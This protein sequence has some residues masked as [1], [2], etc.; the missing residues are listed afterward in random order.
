ASTTPTTT[1]TLTSTS[2]V[3][4]VAAPQA[5][6]YATFDANNVMSTVNGQGILRA[7]VNSNVAQTFVNAASAYDCSVACLNNA[8]CGAAAYLNHGNTCDLVCQIGG[9][10]S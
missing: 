1:S 5:T 6:F 10:C 2:T 3:V 7:F 9:T 4:T 8:D